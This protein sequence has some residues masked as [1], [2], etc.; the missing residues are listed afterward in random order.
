MPGKQY[1]W[2]PSVSWNTY[3]NCW[4]MLMA[5]VEN[6]KWV[7]SSIWMS[8]NFN[9]DLGEGDNAQQ[10]TTPKLILD[11]PGNIIW[12]PSLQPMNTP[13]DIENRYTSLR[14]GRRARLFFKDMEGPESAYYSEYIIEFN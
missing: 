1:Y 12:Y 2:G 3:L 11:K 4:V 10:W 7:G 6:K 14:L 5:K 8:F 9:K 13:E